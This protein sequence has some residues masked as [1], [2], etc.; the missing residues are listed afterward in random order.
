MYEN[1]GKN[2]GRSQSWRFGFGW[3]VFAVRKLQGP[4]E[5]RVPKTCGFGLGSFRGAKTPKAARRAAKLHSF[6]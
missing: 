5:G 2:K 6:R 4:R 3:G 1:R